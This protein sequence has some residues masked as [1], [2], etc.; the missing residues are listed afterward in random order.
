MNGL[1]LL[2]N[3][4]HIG[5]W[6][7]KGRPKSEW[8]YIVR[9]E[10]LEAVTSETPA[11]LASLILRALEGYG[12]FETRQFYLMFKEGLQYYE[13]EHSEHEFIAIATTVWVN[14][15][16]VPVMSVS[17]NAKIVRRKDK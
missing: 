5:E 8:F 13:F 14:T 17:I 15:K 9:N 10:R 7:Q 4:I 11:F 3:G 12:D 1:K 6:I 2:E 16:E